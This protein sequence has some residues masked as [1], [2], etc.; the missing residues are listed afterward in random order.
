MRHIR[1]DGG[2]EPIGQRIIEIPL[3]RT[4]AEIRDSK[5]SFTA[6]VP[7]GSIARGEE[8]AST[9][10]NG[11]T[12]Q[13]AIC[14]GPELGGLGDVPGI[15]GRSPVYMVRQMVDIQHGVRGGA[16]AALMQAVVANLTVEDMINLT[17]YVSSLDP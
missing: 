12:I 16:S 11:K 6:Y 2:M 4:G 1:P 14:H 7:T 15:A 3:D 10:G 17:A 9:G 13:C 8:L 5:A